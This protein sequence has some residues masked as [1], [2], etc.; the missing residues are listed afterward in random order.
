MNLEQLCLD[1]IRKEYLSIREPIIGDTQ[2]WAKVF[3][4]NLCFLPSE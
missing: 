3:G 1:W 4:M 2:K